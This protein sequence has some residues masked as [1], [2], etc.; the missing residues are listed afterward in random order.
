MTL[1][2]GLGSSNTFEY[3]GSLPAIVDSSSL[4]ITTGARSI[5]AGSNCVLTLLKA[6]FPESDSAS[7]IMGMFVV[8]AA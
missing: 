7:E 4:T 8:A 1:T 2:I 6:P 5:L 3:R